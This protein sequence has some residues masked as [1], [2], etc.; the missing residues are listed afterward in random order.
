M[1]LPSHL[2]VLNCL[3][4]YLITIILCYSLFRHQRSLIQLWLMDTQCNTKLLL[5][6]S[7]RG[8]NI[9][10]ITH[11]LTFVGSRIT[12]AFPLWEK[13]QE[14]VHSQCET[15]L[16]VPDSYNT[17]EH[18]QR[19]WYNNIENEYSLWTSST[20]LWNEVCIKFIYEFNNF[21]I[22]NDIHRNYF[23]NLIRRNFK[24][25]FLRLS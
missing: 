3:F 17:G 24:T 11:R 22:S 8:W 14:N 12:A 4:K 15:R 10:E 23:Y 25:Y 21:Q 1:Q 9:L 6:K 7:S 18:C 20:M 2:N 13:E 16:F 19:L 5:C